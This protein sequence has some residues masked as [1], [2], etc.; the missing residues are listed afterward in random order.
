MS[1]RM[2]HAMPALIVLVSA[3][4][5]CAVT[6]RRL[7]LEGRDPDQVWNA[8]V[9]VAQEP[10]YMSSEDVAQRW[11]VRTN[12][13]AADPDASGGGRIE[14]Y[15]RLERELHMP[16]APVRHETREWKFNIVLEQRDPPLILFTARN[17]SVPAH[18]WQ[19]AERYFNEVQGFL[20]GM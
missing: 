16:G 11:V 10:D 1:M 8:M 9:A 19:E 18:V 12:E 2:L 7:L 6:E 20:E 5:G 4:S 13:V 17:A 15:R 14:V 3:L